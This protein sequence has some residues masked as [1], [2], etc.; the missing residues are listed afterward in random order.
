M[1]EGSTVMI[2]PTLLAILFNIN[3]FFLGISAVA[4]PYNLRHAFCMDKISRG[5]SNYENQKV[6]TNCMDNADM[7]IYQYEMR[8]RDQQRRSQERD[9]RY[10][11]DKEE[12]EMREQRKMDSLFKMFE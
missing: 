8:K 7:L 9:A 4:Y 1:Q 10:R 6:Y 2:Y 5:R 3:Y 11:K 12:R